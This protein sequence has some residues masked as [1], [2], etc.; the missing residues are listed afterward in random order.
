MSDRLKE[1]LKTW[2]APLATAVVLAFFTTWFT[3][4]AKTAKLYDKQAESETVIR[5]IDEKTDIIKQDFARYPEPAQIARKDELT[6]RFDAI[7]RE[8]QS[9]SIQVSEIRQNQ[10]RK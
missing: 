7:L 6:V 1:I 4:H 5:S 10:L 8:L 2:V 3:D 9:I